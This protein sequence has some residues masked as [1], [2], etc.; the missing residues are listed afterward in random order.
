MPYP[1]GHNE[2]IRE[3]IIGEARK[4]FNLRGYDGVTIDDVMKAAGLTRG[5]FYFHFPSKVALYRESI[6]HILKDHPFTRWTKPQPG[7]P[8][9]QRLVD[10]YLSE[11][12]L[13]D[14]EESCPLVTHA[15]ESARHDPET[16]ET[17]ASVMRMLVAILDKDDTGAGDREGL[18]VAALCV[19]GLSLA[20]GVG[21]RELARHVLRA[22]R[23]A[24]YELSGWQQPTTPER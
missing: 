4:A 11:R 3:R 24:A 10:A 20:R 15:A 14:R 17:F 22:T 6:A 16:Q 18:A 21:D 23:S 7:Q 19:G 1:K 2:E 5:A 13:D 9:A 8:M 12:H